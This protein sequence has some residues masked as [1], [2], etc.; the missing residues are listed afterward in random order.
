VVNERDWDDENPGWDSGLF[1]RDSDHVGEWFGA[2]EEIGAPDP[3][4]WT[5][6]DVYLNDDGLVIDV[7]DSDGNTWTYDAFDG[8]LKGDNMEDWDWVWQIWDWLDDV[9]ADVDKD[10]KYDER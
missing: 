9:Y 5:N 10:S 1:F 3:S 7:T 2:L 8:E 4:E 6:Y